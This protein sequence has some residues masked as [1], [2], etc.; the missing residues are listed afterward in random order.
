[1]TDRRRRVAALAGAV[2]A[3]AATLGAEW[4]AA[5]Q[6]RRHLSLRTA[7]TTAAYLSLVTPA[8]RDT[9][10]SLDPRKLLI[11]VRALEAL[12]GWTPAVEVYHGTAPLVHGTAPPL[13]PLD[14]LRLRFEGPRWERGV[15][16]APLTLRGDRHAV[17]AVEVRTSSGRGVPGTLTAL[18]CLATLAAAARAAVAVPGTARRG[19]IIYAASSVVLGVAAYRDVWSATRSATD[20]WLSD[21]RLLIQ[22]AAARSPK[23]PGRITPVDFTTVT[24]SGEL[25]RSDSAG[26][27]PRRRRFGD[28]VRATVTVRIGPGRWMELRTAAEEESVGGW[29]PLLVGV[30]LLG[31]LSGLARHYH[32]DGAVV[33]QPGP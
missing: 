7:T 29:L 19:L 21:T 17:G 6:V 4:W 5:R 31:P 22:E 32:R 3:V 26:P 28:E 24:A 25:V 30:A 2:L 13:T 15:A 10:P 9:P 20:R 11:A 23:R 27:L 33:Q 1:M 16:R 14:L 18:I 8:A 12:P